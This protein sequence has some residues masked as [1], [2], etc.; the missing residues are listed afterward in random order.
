MLMNKYFMD[1]KNLIAASLNLDINYV[2]MSNELLNVQHT[3]NCVPFSYPAARGSNEEVTA[4]SLFLRTNPSFK[5]YSYRGAKQ[6]E[7]TDWE[8]DSTLDIS[9]TQSVIESLPF[10]VLGTIRVVYFPGVPCVEHTD[11]DDFKDSEHTLGLSII[12]STGDT[13]CNV[14]NKK[15]EKYIQIP[16]N[17]MLLNDSIKHE[18]PRP[19]GTRIT[20][21]VFGKIDYSWFIDKI[22]YEHCYFN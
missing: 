7:V 10:D 19:N 16:G 1:F 9:Y 22:N 21:R 3:P 8:W 13:W 6:A 12:P 4:Y 14:W 17:A 2:R 11:W 20:I 18:V 5:N 15:Q